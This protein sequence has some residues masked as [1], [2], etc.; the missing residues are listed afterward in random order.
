MNK[1]VWKKQKGILKE[2]QLMKRPET[3]AD[4]SE[5]TFGTFGILTLQQKTVLVVF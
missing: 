5:E 3:I 4:L 1:D 2:G